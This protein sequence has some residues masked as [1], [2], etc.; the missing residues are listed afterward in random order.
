MGSQLGISL[1]EQHNDAIPDFE[2]MIIKENQDTGDL[3]QPVDPNGFPGE[4][5][6]Y[7][8]RYIH[9]RVALIFKV[10]NFIQKTLFSSSWINIKTSCFQVL[11]NSLVISNVNLL[12]SSYQA[13]LK[14]CLFPLLNKLLTSKEGEMKAAGL[15]ILG[16]FCGLSILCSNLQG[17]NPNSSDDFSNF[18]EN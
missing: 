13:R 7:D 16:S 6:C 10:W 14:D 17:K 3:N 15:N 5:E 8:L 12:C 11:C 18:D 2:T 1:Y 4:F 9:S